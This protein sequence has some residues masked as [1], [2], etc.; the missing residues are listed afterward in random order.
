ME[1]KDHVILT[2]TIWVIIT[3]S[4]IL[5][6][7][8][9]FFTVPTYNYKSVFVA[10]IFIC[11]FYFSGASIPDWDHESVL[12]KKYYLFIRWI[13]FLN[14]HRGWW[15]SYPAMYIYGSVICILMWV[16]G[17]KLWFFVFLA[18]MFGFYTHLL[19]DDLIRFN[20]VRYMYGKDP[21]K[22]KNQ[23]RAGKFYIKK[24][25]FNYLFYGI[26]GYIIIFTIVLF[27]KLL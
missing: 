25:G 21:L 8:S 10:G 23:P 20:S 18:G 13:G 11:I 24:D 3:T 2:M 1:F 12:G 9:G 17:V 6:L 4:F 16:L 19:G 14:K 22:A 26:Y 7:F 27:Y 5:S 15:H